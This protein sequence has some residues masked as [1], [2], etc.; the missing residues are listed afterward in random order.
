M[1]NKVLAPEHRG[2]LGEPEAVVG[3]VQKVTKAFRPRSENL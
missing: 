3:S 1:C 2:L